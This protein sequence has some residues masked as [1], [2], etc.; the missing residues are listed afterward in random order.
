MFLF[1]SENAWIDRVYRPVGCCLWHRSSP[2]CQGNH[3]GK[4]PCYDRRKLKLFC[5]LCVPLSPSYIYVYFSLYEKYIFLC[6]FESDVIV[7]I[8]YC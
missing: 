1:I 8:L 3:Q 2:A 6:L 4:V 7:T 5:F